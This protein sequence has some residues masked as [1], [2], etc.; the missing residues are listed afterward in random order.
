MFIIASVLMAIIVVFLLLIPWVIGIIRIL[1][2]IMYSNN[3]KK[4]QELLKK[5]EGKVLKSKPSSARSYYRNYYNRI[6]GKTG[7]KYLFL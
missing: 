4:R 2:V 1:V 5:D 6:V 3:I 7:T